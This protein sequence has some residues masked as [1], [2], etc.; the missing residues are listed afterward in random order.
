M[1]IVY[2]DND[3]VEVL[4]NN[5]GPA[6]D[7]LIKDRVLI[8][9]EDLNRFVELYGTEKLSA[10]TLQ[11]IED[12]RSHRI[13]KV[14]GRRQR[15]SFLIQWAQVRD[16]YHFYTALMEAIDRKK[17]GRTDLDMSHIVE[18]FLED[19]LIEAVEKISAMDDPKSE[20]ALEIVRTLFFS[21]P[22]C[23]TKR[24]EN[25]FSQVRQTGVLERLSEPQKYKRRAA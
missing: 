10:A 11:H 15:P 25:M 7:R 21:G 9:L 4:D 2:F 24:I 13:C 17:N 22:N 18:E 1:I 8:P 6:I 14:A 3:Q 12:Q 23:S 20:N 5:S 19:E 16:A